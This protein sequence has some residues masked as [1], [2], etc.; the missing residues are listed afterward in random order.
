LKFFKECRE[1]LNEGG[2]LLVCDRLPQNDSE[3]DRALFMTEQE[4]V[5]ALGQAG[6]LDAEVLLRTSER[7]ACKSVKL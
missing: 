5:A 7:V 4:Q 2:L 1:L 6:F 3:R